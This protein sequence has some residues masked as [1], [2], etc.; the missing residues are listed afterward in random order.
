MS[1]EQFA[2]HICFRYVFY[3]IDG[4]C[5]KQLLSLIIRISSM[6]RYVLHFNTFLHCGGEFHKKNVYGLQKCFHSSVVL[7]TAQLF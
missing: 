4:I 5:S 1:L 3:R 7:L 2:S 6:L